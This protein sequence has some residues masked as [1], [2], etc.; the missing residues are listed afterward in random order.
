MNHM[1][2]AEP[3]ADLATIT[4][5]VLFYATGGCAFGTVLIAR[6]VKGVCAILLGDDARALE[7]DLARRFPHS[8]LVPNEV[9]VRDDMAKVARYADKPSDGLDLTLDMR[10]TPIQRRVWNALRSIPL[11]KTRSYMQVARLINAAYPQV[12]ARIVA[13]ACAA[14][15]LALVI[16][17]HRVIRADGE[18]AGYC[19]GLERKRELLEKEAR[20]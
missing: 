19:W 5:D 11:G 10:G 7:D 3:S 15:P 2:H 14:N 13:N 9:M 17:C 20:A 12:A 4:A 18:L 8:T 16:P 6:S 1:T